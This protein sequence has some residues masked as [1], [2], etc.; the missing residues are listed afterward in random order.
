MQKRADSFTCGGLV[1][2]NVD[3]Q[4]DEVVNVYHANDPDH[5]TSYRRGDIAEAEPAVPGWRMPLDDLFA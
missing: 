1:V 3:L 4:S 5:P 2:W